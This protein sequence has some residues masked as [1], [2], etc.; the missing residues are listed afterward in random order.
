MKTDEL[1]T[2][3]A[4]GAD[5]IDP[6]ALRR[7]YAL[8]LGWSL[9][10]TTLL[11]LI[12]LGVR[13]DIAVAARLVMFWMKLAF[14]AMLLF[15]ALLA[16]V[17]LSRPGVRLGQ[18]PLAIAAPVIAVWLLSAIVLLNAAPEERNQLI[19]GNTWAS[20]PLTIAALSVP[21]FGA[22]IWTIKGFAPT[23]LA[24][25]GAAAGLLAGAGGALVYA[26]HCPEMAAPFLGIWYVLG[27]LIPAAIGAVV[28]P[29]TLRW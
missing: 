28:G 17:R 3:L 22:L 14:P 12:L 8:A 21:M 27:M 29:W 19:F 5:A 7:R 4:S 9:V 10:G 16:T 18:A 24:L 11:M 23:R 1:I 6:H 25:A 2:M 15:G 13:P 20:C 26:L